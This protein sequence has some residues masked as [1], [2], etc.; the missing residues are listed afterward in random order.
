MRHTIFVPL[1]H[2]QSALR[3]SEAVPAGDGRF[4]LVGSPPKHERLLFKRGEIV[5]CDI[6]ALPGGSK[7]LVAIRS[8]SADTEFQKTQTVFTVFGA[9]MG[10]VLGAVGALWIDTSLAVAGIGAVLG[11]II[12]AFCSRRWGDAA[13]DFLSRVFDG[14]H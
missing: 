11:A 13:W 8:V 9:L 6:R 12:F 2:D 3:E 1:F 14:R 7:G 4:K 10:L 5:E